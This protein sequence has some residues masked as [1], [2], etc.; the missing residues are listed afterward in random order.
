MVSSQWV[1]DNTDHLFDY[2]MRYIDNTGIVPTP[3][4]HTVDKKGRSCTISMDFWDED[5]EKDYDELGTYLE[6]VAEALEAVASLLVFVGSYKGEEI[7]GILAYGVDV[8]LKILI[9]PIIWNGDFMDF[10][11][12]QE[13]TPDDMAYVEF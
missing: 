1:K 10:G 12:A 5:D 4:F 6:G 7:I 8:P 2:A 3:K 13:I 9:K 11:A